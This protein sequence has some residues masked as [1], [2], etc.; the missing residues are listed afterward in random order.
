MR[1]TRQ[2]RTPLVTSY[3]KVGNYEFSMLHLLVQKQSLAA[4]INI[5][6]CTPINGR[7]PVQ[8]LTFPSHLM[9]PLIS[10]AQKNIL[11]FQRSYLLF[12][13]LGI[14]I[15][16]KE[17]AL[18]FTTNISKALRAHFQDIKLTSH[19]CNDNGP[20]LQRH[21]VAWSRK[22]FGLKYSKRLNSRNNSG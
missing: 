5:E 14:K 16:T 7:L 2:Y 22:T 1:E 17:I 20:M 10:N 8:L 11:L 4:N 12:T 6:F 15:K 21:Y 19:N 18:I 9:K 3:I 13:A